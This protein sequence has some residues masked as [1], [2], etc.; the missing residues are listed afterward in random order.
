MLTLI[1]FTEDFVLL[2]NRSMRILC[3]IGIAKDRESVLCFSA[4]FLTQLNLRL[5]QL[6]NYRRKSQQSNNL[7]VSERTGKLLIPVFHLLDVCR[8]QLLNNFIGIAAH[9]RIAKQEM[10]NLLLRHTLC[11]QRYPFRLYLVPAQSLRGGLCV[12]NAIHLPSCTDQ[13]VSVHQLGAKPRHKAALINGVQPQR[14]LCQLNS[15]RV[16]VD[17]INIAVGNEHLDLLQF[18]KSFFIAD[19]LAGFFLLT[20][21]IGL[22]QLIDCLV[23][24]RCT[25]HSRLADGQLENFIRSFSFKKLF[26]GILNQTLGQNL[27]CVIGCGFFTLSTCQTI[28]ESAFFIHTKL[29]RFFTRFVT[30]TL[31]F[32]ILVKLRFRYKVANIQFVKAVT[33]SLYFIEVMFGN[34][35]SIGKKRLV[36]CAHLVDAQICIGNTATAT[37]FSARSPCQGQ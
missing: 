34:K 30:D 20:G 26:Q 6:I 1:E 10:V 35:S 37:I 25:A 14:N 31:I 8:L 18:I 3:I 15:H 32:G 9:S 17:A 22:C 23:Q 21:D 4:Y 36:H 19:D 28:N 29:A 13:G 11:S 12:F 33:G 27:R 5:P 2:A 7:I 24:E 16:Q